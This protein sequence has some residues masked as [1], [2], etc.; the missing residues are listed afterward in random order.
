M[1]AGTL[2]PAYETARLKLA[3]IQVDGQQARALAAQ[4]AAQI[5]ADAL[6]VER[7]GIWFLRSGARKLVCDHLFSRSKLES[8]AAREL[9]TSAIPTFMTALR[10]R[11]VVASSDARNHPQTRELAPSYL[12]PAGVGAL[13]SAPIIRE[14]QLAGVV[15]HEHVGS[16]RDWQQREL[17]FAC[18]VADMV[19]LILEQADRVELEAAL[20]VQA[21]LRL[22]NQKMEAL[23]RLARSVAH[24]FNNVLAV[25]KG[26]GGEL[27]HLQQLDE[28][29]PMLG[30]QLQRVG[31]VG[32]R[33][34]GQLLALGQ[35]QPPEQTHT[36]LGDVL[37]AL[38]PVLV[39]LVGEK[40][41]LT[42]EMQTQRTNVVLSRQAI[43]QIL[44][45]LCANARDALAASGS[46]G[47]R[48]RDAMPGEELG[49]DALVMEVTDDGHGMDEPTAKR[50]FEPYFTTKSH[51]HGLG[52]SLVH[53]VVQRA[54]G[55]VYFESTPGQGTRF[56]VG[57]PRPPD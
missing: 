37:A 35:E 23:G 18:S 26:V 43:E 48:V 47:V 50:V 52:L 38:Q 44:L 16:T 2:R 25:V 14:G 22:E 9:A 3:R 46:I 17:D 6:E 10:E 12:E 45:N 41:R 21:E 31:E 39:S 32:E 15:C 40:A 19:A 30:R 5:S 11:R 49:V 1:R 20:Q 56:V 53:A 33:L 27:H 4:R 8:T 28:A 29:L 55:H 13:L 57:L 34:T 54:G 51:G 42:I 7:V 36:V 24:D